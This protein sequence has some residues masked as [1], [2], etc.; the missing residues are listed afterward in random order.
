MSPAVLSAGLLLITLALFASDK[1]RHDLVAVLSLLAA[2]L[3]GLVRPGEAFAGFGDSAVITVAAVLVIGRAVELSGAATMLVRALMPRGAPLPV[4]IAVV[5]VLGAALSAFMNNIAALAITMPVMIRICRDGRMSPAIGLMPLSFATIL[6]GM[7][8]LIGTPANLIL[9]SVREEQLGAPFQFFDMTLVG[10]AVTLV[11]LAYLM[12]A[13]WRLAPKRDSGAAMD[14]DASLRVFELWAPLNFNRRYEDVQQALREAEVSLLAVWRDHA[15]VVL[16]GDDLVQPGDCLIVSARTDPWVAAKPLDLRFEAR[17]M[18]T[19]DAAT[20]R[21]VVGDGSPLIGFSYGVV[22][23]QTD[24]E[25]QVIAG[26]DR[27]ARERRPLR[28]MT[29]RAGDQIVVQGPAG[30]LAEYI[31][32]GRLLQLDRR[33]TAPPK[34]RRA[35]VSVLVYA[36]AVV[37]TAAFGVPAALSFVA[38]AGLMIVLRLLPADEVYRSI[39]WPV[40]VLLGAMIPVGKSF[41]DSGASEIAAAWLSHAMGDMTLFWALAAMTLATAIFSM[42]LNNVATAIVMGPVAMQAAVALGAPPDAF[43]LAVL[44]GASSD[45]LTPIGHQNNLLVMGPGGYR[46]LDYPRIGL[47]MMVLVVLTTAFVLSRVYGG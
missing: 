25:L 4:R 46:F 10:G 39:D 3:L 1:V 45:F 32:Y 44:I 31:R 12:I 36:A 40:I 21:L 35:V 27:M 30:V 20:A 42:F 37:A 26:G 38:A 7:T 23:A 43:L 34:P 9:S 19:D 8:T 41:G 2:V 22:D 15:R 28:A 14:E 11:G 47:L 18:N 16:A 17:R 6:G 29:L 13:G 5:L 33:L 24:G